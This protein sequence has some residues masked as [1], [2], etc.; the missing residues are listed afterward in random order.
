M[1]ENKQMISRDYKSP[2]RDALVVS[3]SL[4]IFSGLLLD[5]GIT[6]WLFSRAF[7]VLWATTA[8]IVIR[9]PKTP[10]KIDVFFIRWGFLLIVAALI[11]FEVLWGVVLPGRYIGIMPF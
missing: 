5:M 6:S 9:R 2:I 7:V 8:V 3:I 11:G 10:T 4:L 1:S